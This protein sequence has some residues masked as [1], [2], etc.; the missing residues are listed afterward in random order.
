VWAWD[1]EK[2]KENTVVLEYYSKS[3][4]TIE[5]YWFLRHLVKDPAVDFKEGDEPTLK[6]WNNVDLHKCAKLIE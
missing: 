1:I 4:K 5:Y 2:S 6:N 3:N